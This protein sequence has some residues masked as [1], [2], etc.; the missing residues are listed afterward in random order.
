MNTQTT[1]AIHEDADSFFMNN[2]AEVSSGTDMLSLIAQELEVV[3]AETELLQSLLKDTTMLHF[4]KI[5]YID[6]RAHYCF[7]VK[8]HNDLAFSLSAPFAASNGSSVF[9]INSNLFT[10][11][12]TFEH[13]KNNLN[14]LIRVD[15]K[16]TPNSSRKFYQEVFDTIQLIKE[17]L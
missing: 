3:G 2:M 1:N 9:Y 14:A 12:L 4:F 8:D 16:L 10:A 7:D 13:F 6:Q 15:Q 17:K 11:E 5:S